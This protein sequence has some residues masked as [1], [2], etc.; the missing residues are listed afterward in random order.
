MA[1]QVPSSEKKSNGFTFKLI[2]AGGILVAVGI[3]FLSR[4][5]L[6][7]LSREACYHYYG[8]NDWWSSPFSSLVNSVVSTYQCEW[9]GHYGFQWH[10][11]A[12]LLTNSWQTLLG[13]VGS[14]LGLYALGQK[15]NAQP[16]QHTAQPATQLDQ[17]KLDQLFEAINKGYLPLKQVSDQKRTELDNEHLSVMIDHLDAQKEE[18]ALSTLKSH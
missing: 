7:Y 11:I 13:A 17:T 3:V 2:T 18:E 4:P 14:G 12:S 1:H 9:V 10:E 6:A 5:I 8:K 15:I 16:C